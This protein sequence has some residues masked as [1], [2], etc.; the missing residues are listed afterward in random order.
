MIKAKEKSD[1]KH[2]GVYGDAEQIRLALIKAGREVSSMVACGKNAVGITFAGENGARTTVT[3]KRGADL[4]KI[5]TDYKLT[6][7]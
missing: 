7:A 3:V 1:I 6:P 4:K 5:Y 2:G